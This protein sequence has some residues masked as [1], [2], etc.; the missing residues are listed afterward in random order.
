MSNNRAQSWPHNCSICGRVYHLT[1]FMWRWVVSPDGSNFKED[2]HRISCNQY[3]K[4]GCVIL[5]RLQY[6][7]YTSVGGH[8]T[9]RDGGNN[10]TA[11]RYSG[12]FTTKKAD[13]S[14]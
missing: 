14:P 3:R 9:D 7:Q 4:K 5:N 13:P 11:R 10:Q 2:T 8:R 6:D 1:N 12:M